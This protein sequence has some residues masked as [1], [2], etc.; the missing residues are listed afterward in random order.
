MNNHLFYCRIIYCFMFLDI[1]LADRLELW[2]SMFE[3]R[4]ETTSSCHMRTTK[5]HSRSLISAFSAYGLDSIILYLLYPK[6][7]D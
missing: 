7:Q 1:I 3:P 4:H 2:T 6:F 5:T